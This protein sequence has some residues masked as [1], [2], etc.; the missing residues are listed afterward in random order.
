MRRKL[1]NLD[2]ALPGTHKVV[3]SY[4]LTIRPVCVVAKEEGP[5]PTIV[6]GFPT[7]SNSGNGSQRLRDIV[8]QPFKNRSYYI[9][10]RRTGSKRR[11]E[12]L[13]QSSDTPTKFMR[14]RYDNLS[15]V[16]L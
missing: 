14:A 11:I 4:L 12:S 1:A 10:V 3:C 15:L 13:R 7:R 16:G 2:R 8:C 5:Y 9:R 6:R